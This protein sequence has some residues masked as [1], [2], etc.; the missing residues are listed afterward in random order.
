MSLFSGPR[1]MSTPGNCPD[2]NLCVPGY[3]FLSLADGNHRPPV[4][5]PLLQ[6]VVAILLL[7]N[8]CCEQSCKAGCQCIEGLAATGMVFLPMPRHVQVDCP[9]CHFIVDDIAQK[10]AS[11]FLGGVERH[12]H[13]NAAFLPFRVNVDGLREFRLQL[14]ITVFCHDFR[15]SQAAR[16][17][18]VDPVRRRQWRVARDDPGCKD[19]KAD[20]TRDYF[21]HRSILLSS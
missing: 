4:F 1:H 5:V 11:Q 7:S 10:N 9:R 3:E 19:E 14:E 18:C 16:L 13:T 21:L 8:G 6:Y 12:F 20:H 2:E 15:I 17:G